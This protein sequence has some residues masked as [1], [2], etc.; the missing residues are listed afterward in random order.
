[1]GV[2]GVVPAAGWATRLN[3]TDGS[4]EML[5]VMGKPVMDYLI[6]RMRVAAPDSIRV[7]TRPAKLDVIRHS[8]DLGLEVR[9]AETRSVNESIAVA[10]KGLE[11]DD[12]VLIGFPDSIWEPLAGYRLLLDRLSPER[13]V[14]L[15]LFTWREA[16][17]GDVVVLDPS[18]RVRGIVAKPAAPSSNLIWACAV[19]AA[20]ALDGIDKCEFPGEHFATLC[21]DGVVDALWLSDRYIDVGTPSSLN[22]AQSLP[23]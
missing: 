10:I 12:I 1:M 7:V 3:L 2:V 23:N 17:R 18:G 16:E 22:V 20:S 21:P 8:R 9:L 15:G 11:P 14:V 13:T 19:A 5:T 4:K 6:D